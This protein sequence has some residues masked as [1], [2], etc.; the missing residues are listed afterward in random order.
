MASAQLR[1]YSPNDYLAD[2]LERDTKHEYL[3][4]SIY[5]IAGASSRN[6][7]HIISNLV[8]AF[9]QHLR[10][11]PC[12]T[13][14]SDM[15]VK[16]GDLAFFYP[17]VVVTCDDQTDGNAYYTEAPKI[18]VE[19]LSKSTR[20]HDETTKRRLYQSL[21]SLQE[22]VLIEQDI[23]DVEI[24]RRSNHWQSEHFFMGDTVTFAVLE[25]T[26]TV[27]DIYERV[28][29]DDVSTYLAQLAAASKEVGDIV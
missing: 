25:L 9:V 5:A 7:Q 23:V 27:Q 28:V 14:A 29:N 1:F 12:A 15:K 2:E 20:R 18:I 22:Y 4:G 19:V 3:N 26:L 17:D 6:H 11:T 10:G 24:C 8:M 16:I 21:P 13:Y